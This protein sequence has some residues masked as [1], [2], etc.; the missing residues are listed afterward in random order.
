MTYEGNADAILPTS[1]A[2][3]SVMGSD[4]GLRAAALMAEKFRFLVV[5]VAAAKTR[6]TGEMA[7]RLTRTV[8]RRALTRAVCMITLKRQRNKQTDFLS[9]IMNIYAR[10][11]Q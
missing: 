6:D 2:R 7:M 1:P 3:T 11:M 10:I 8:D 5:P 4:H 9:I